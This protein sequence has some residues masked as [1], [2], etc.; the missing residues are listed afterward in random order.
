MTVLYDVQSICLP[1]FDIF[2]LKELEQRIINDIDGLYRVTLSK[3]NNI[4]VLH[5]VVDRK[6]DGIALVCFTAAI[7]ER[8]DKTAPFFSGRELSKVVNLPLISIADPVVSEQNINLAWYAGS[9]KNTGVQTQISKILDTFA[10]TSGYHTLILIGGSGAG[11]ASLIQLTLETKVHLK[12]LIWNPQTSIF[13]YFPRFV[14]EYMNVAFREKLKKNIEYKKLMDGLGIKYEIDP[15]EILLNNSYVYLQNYPDIHH[16][17]EHLMPFIHKSQF[18]WEKIGEGAYINEESNG[19][20]YVADWGKGHASP[21]FDLIVKLINDFIAIDSI[22][23]ILTNVEKRYVNTSL[24]EIGV[25]LYKDDKLWDVNISLE[26]K[27][28]KAKVF[29]EEYKPNCQ[30][31]FYLLE[32]NNRVDHIYYQNLNYHT[33]DISQYDDHSALSVMAFVK[34]TSGEKLIKIKKQS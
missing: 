30:Y 14:G 18:H 12:A 15:N 7:S 20:V 8:I 9:E 26:R 19:G 25:S 23:S 6:R 22:K 28:L 33:F 29:F 17:K 24:K 21:P 5:E 31:A 2:S 10:T 32:N 4:D 13:N 16:Y 3:S 27:K 34:L 1:I 11:F